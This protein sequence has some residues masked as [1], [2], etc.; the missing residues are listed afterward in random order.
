MNL[1]IKIFYSPFKTHFA[2]FDSN[3]WTKVPTSFFFKTSNQT[4]NQPFT[5]I[6]ERELILDTSKNVYIRPTNT[7]SEHD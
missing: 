2:T 7:R 5:L 4:K 3:E 6:A 1:I